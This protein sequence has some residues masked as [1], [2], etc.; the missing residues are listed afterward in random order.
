MT[1]LDNS[2][3]LVQIE[4]PVQGQYGCGFVRKTDREN[5]LLLKEPFV[6]E[7]LRRK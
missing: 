4:R 5:R 6:K 1:E 2:L 7:C 3:E